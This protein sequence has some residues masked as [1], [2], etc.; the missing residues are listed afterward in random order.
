MRKYLILA[1]LVGWSMLWIGCSKSKPVVEEVA[2]EAAVEYDT[3]PTAAFDDGEHIIEG[4]MNRWEGTPYGMT[5]QEAYMALDLVEEM[6]ND[7]SV[8]KGRLL[9]LMIQLNDISGKNTDFAWDYISSNFGEIIFDIFYYIR[10]SV[11]PKAS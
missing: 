9:E 6:A 3:T 8:T 7:P 1:L 4:D 2:V 5:Q 10:H 11:I